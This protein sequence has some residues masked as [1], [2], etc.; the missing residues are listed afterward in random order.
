M[1]EDQL[2]CLAAVVLTLPVAAA[3]GVMSAGRARQ[4]VCGGVGVGVSLGCF[5]VQNTLRYAMVATLS[6]LLLHAAAIATRCRR[7]FLARLFYALAGSVCFVL[8]LTVHFLRVSMPFLADVLPLMMLSVKL[9]EMSFNLYDYSLIQRGEKRAEYQQNMAITRMPN[10]LEFYSYC[11]F[12]FGIFSGPVFEFT[13]YLEFTLS[14]F[15]APRMKKTELVKNLA[16]SLVSSV[17]FHIGSPY[18]S[19][20]YLSRSAPSTCV[21]DGS[22]FPAS[23]PDMNE[24]HWQCMPFL[25]QILYLWIAGV[26]LRMRYYFV[27][28]YLEAAGVACGLSY[29]EGKWGGLKNSHFMDCELAPS[30]LVLTRSWNLSISSTW[31]KRYVHER[32]PFASASFRVVTVYVI[33]AVWHGWYLGN[34]LSYAT[35]V[36]FFMVAVYWRQHFEPTMLTIFNK[37]VYVT[38]SIAL[39]MASLSY[40]I[41]GFFVLDLQKTLAIY[42]GMDYLG[43]KLGLILFVMLLAYHNFKKCSKKAEKLS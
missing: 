20:D 26:I 27:W 43:H 24:C 22:L 30:L 5:G 15:P 12:F 2:R 34:L 23:L 38:L 18:F 35:I 37:T 31:L 4:A 6:F 42:S 25:L 3:V 29:S 10:P 16:K 28:Y 8:L 40:G 1:D 36:M 9:W 11:F 33:S 17:L 41:L 19:L 14:P 39:T 21:C 7:F 32:V 13:K